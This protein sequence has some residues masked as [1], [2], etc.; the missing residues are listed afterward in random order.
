[1]VVFP[2]SP[3]VA[4]MVVELRNS[5]QKA[6]CSR[7]IVESPEELSSAARTAGAAA[8]AAA[9]RIDPA[10]AAGPIV[11]RKC[12][13]VC[14]LTWRRSPGP[15]RGCLIHLLLPWPPLKASETMFAVR[16]C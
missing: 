12:R 11:N 6:S 15:A 3:V 1:M 5:F 7:L 2:I 13:L 4:V 8:A 9:A 16:C 14:W 10:V